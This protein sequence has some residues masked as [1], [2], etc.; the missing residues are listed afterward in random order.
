MAECG[1]GLSV[2]ILR[3]VLDGVEGFDPCD[4]LVGQGRAGDFG[5][6]E[7]ATGV[8]PATDFDDGAATLFEEWIVSTTTVSR[9]RFFGSDFRPWPFGFEMGLDS[10]G[11]ST[12]GGI[13]SGGGAP[14]SEP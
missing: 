9:R 14:K 7:L 5:F 12:G 11:N 3:R 4:G 2:E 10:K 6:D 8:G 1:A 13:G